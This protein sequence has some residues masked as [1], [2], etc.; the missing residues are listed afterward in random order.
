MLVQAHALSQI[1][2]AVLDKRPLLVTWYPWVE[3]GWICIWSLTGGAAVATLLV[4]QKT[5]H[6]LLGLAVIVTASLAILYI[7]CLVFFL[8]GY[9]VPLVPP[10]LT[11][12]GS[13]GIT[14]I[15]NSKFL[16]KNS[17]QANNSTTAGITYF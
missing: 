2:S 7:F 9:W 1:L 17:S 5:R 8:Q 11:L 13:I 14:A 10:V 12:T 15:L 6:S 4:W 3:T 16:G